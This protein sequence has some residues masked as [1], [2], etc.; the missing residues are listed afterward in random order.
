MFAIVDCN[1]FYASCEQVFRPDLKGKPVVVLSNNDGCIVAANKQA[2][3]IADMPLFHAYHKV[4]KALK[5]NDVAIFSSNYALYAEMS[6]RVMR[7]LRTYTPEMEVYSIDEAFLWLGGFEGLPNF[8][9]EDYAVKMKTQV[10]QW[11]GIPVGIGIGPT[12]TLAKVANKLAKK[13]LGNH[14]QVYVIENTTESIAK[15]L[16][17]LPLEKVWGIGRRNARMLQQK[18]GIKTAYD[19]STIDDKWIRLNMTVVGHRMKKELNGQICL[20]LDEDIK[21]TKKHL[22]TAKS[23]GRQTTDFSLVEEAMC[24]YVSELAEKLRDQKSL[25]NYISLFLHTNPFRQNADQKFLRTSITLPYATAN[26]SML[27]KY[28]RQGLRNIFT[29]GYKYKKVGVTLC[30]LVPKNHLQTKLFTENEHD[31]A[32]QIMPT[33][34]KLNRALGKA[35]VQTASCGKRRKQWRIKQEK[36]SPKYTTRWSD[37]LTIKI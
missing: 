14:N 11:T 1:S 32:D 8:S 17:Q 3:Q 36:L 19:F 31:G 26:T 24:F 13:Q 22:A 37:I 6:D 34:D 2:K 28:A 12:K 15:A 25:A 4:E 20:E 10:E 30:G 21:P 35:S 33:L 23:F 18:L 7:I 29:L 27:T 9:Y 16:K 5:A